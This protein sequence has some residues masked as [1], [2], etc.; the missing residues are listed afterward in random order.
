[1][2]NVSIEKLEW[3][4][5]H[6]FKI[7]KV[8]GHAEAISY[9][10]LEDINENN[11]KWK[12]NLNGLWKFNYV[13]KPAD[14]PEKFFD[15]SY[16]TS[17][18]DDIEVPGVWE[19]KGYGKPFYLTFGYPPAIST[20]KQKIPSINKKDNPV[21]SYKRKFNISKEWLERET[22]IHFGAVKSAFY[23]WV[24]GELVGY[25]QGSMTPAEFNIT[26]YLKEGENDLAVQVFKYSDG[27]YLENQDT[28]FLSG[29]YRD[30][31][32]YSEPKTYIRDFFTRCTLDEQYKDAKMTT[33]IWI[34]NKGE[35]SKNLKLE[36]FLEN[37]LLITA[38]VAVNETS[39]EK[40]YINKLI[41]NPRKWTAETPNLYKVKI[42]LKDENDN[43]IQVK[44]TDFGFR[45]LE[46]F[47]SKF[48]INGKPIIFKG[49][50]RHDFDPDNAWYVPK[51]RR[52]QDIKIMKK[53]N[54]N[55]IRTSHYPND[56]H[57]YELCNKYGLYVIDEA[58]LETHGVKTKGVPGDNP[59]WTDAVIDRVERMVQRDKNYPC[60]V[61]WSLGN[62][63]GYGSNFEAMKEAVLNIDNTRPVH[64]EDDKEFK[65]SDV[66]SLMYPTLEKEEKVGTLEPIKVNFLQNLMNRL[67]ADNKAFTVEQYK[68]KP[69]MN[70]EFAHA[71]GNSL[72][73]FKEHID[74]FEKYNNWCGGFIK[75]FVDQSI[76]K[77]ENGVVKWLYGVDFEESRTHGHFCNN[78]IIAADRSYHP[79]IYE[80]KKVYQNIH[81]EMVDFNDSILKLKIYN[82]NIFK[83]LSDIN[84]VYDLK[85]N[86]T[87]IEQK[88]VKSIDIEPGENKKVALKIDKEITEDK[89]YVFTISYRLKE[90][91][92]WA[93]KD[94]EIAWEQFFINEWQNKH[95]NLT[96]G[97]MSRAEIVETEGIIKVSSNDF[98]I[99]INKETG[100][101]SKL[102]F[103]KGN[104]LNKEIELNF[105]RAL[106]DNDIGWSKSKKLLGKMN[107][108]DYLQKLVNRRKVER[109]KTVINGDKTEI[110]FEISMPNLNEPNIIKY[111][112][113]GLGEIRVTNILNPKI[114]L[115]RFGMQAEILNTY[116]NIKWYGRGPHENYID[117]KTGAKVGIYKMTC[118]EFIH[119]YMRPQENGNRTDI[120]F[121][122]ISGEDEAA[123]KVISSGKKLLEMSMWPYTQDE[124]ERAMHIHE[125]K[126]GK[127]TILNIDYGQ[128]GVGGDSN[129]GLNL[130]DKYKLVKDKKYKYSFTIKKC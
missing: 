86:G 7:N 9:D 126:K 70:C 58:D 14:K 116:T 103:G 114:D 17:K 5:P 3:E 41:K 11:Q 16:D 24:N 112:I 113:S 77:E 96:N 53:N 33:E 64:Y 95:G 20:K 109:C 15:C 117:R 6:I 106:T 65:V 18:W 28:W 57:L 94:F 100:N 93:E 51:W 44:E 129:D 115:I 8:D 19:L 105:W 82:K 107:E 10:S 83:N 4:N 66:F 48:L 71:M 61:M 122:E 75:D 80:V 89:E 2:K 124:L 120:R 98:K 39:E 121:V 78:G 37:E 35:E 42:V 25:S 40:V 22:F 118:E 26:E 1:M 55:A 12:F 119:D 32:L 56:P 87:I 76:R 111:E 128:C 81:T 69:V 36:L 63:A 31:Y 72:G 99:E 125:L 52:E 102:D 46:I 84:L 97:E 49:V 47:K 92:L 23:L 101:I 108:N 43:I 30:V 21:G 27:T 127:V 74:N 85:E 60:I 38:G 59:D 104:I 91:S 90:K 13:L 62:D 29:I 54:I 110:H 73:N 79:T 123:F 45:T 34:D 88:I 130:I 67:D 68:N 50:N